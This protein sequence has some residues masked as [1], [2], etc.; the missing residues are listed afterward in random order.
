LSLAFVDR[1]PTER[2]IERL[3]LILSTYQDGSGMLV[4]KDGRTIPGWRDFE[5]SVAAAFGGK[6]QE[7]K[8]IFDVLLSDLARPGRNYGLSCK[9][10][11]TLDRISKDDR[12]T[13]E[14]SNSAGKFWQYLKTKGIDQNNYRK[15]PLEV[16][17]ALVEQVEQWHKVVSIEHGGTIDISKSSYL[18]LSYNNR[19]LYQLH[20][21]SLHLPNPNT[22]KWYFPTIVKKGIQEPANHL[23]GLDDYGAVFEWYGESG[24][25]LKY[26]PRATDAIWRSE[27][28]KLEPIEQENFGLLRKAEAYFPQAWGKLSS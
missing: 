7:S 13:I 25:Q 27:P 3:R 10:R 23:R 8:A 1:N 19:G 18:V 26:Y 14:L 20:Q 5:R 21:F 16:G 4:L 17:I 28:F 9:M 24:G 2:E 22:L 11:A 6:A 15:M 12:V